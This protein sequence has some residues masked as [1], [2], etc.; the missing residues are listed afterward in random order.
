MTEQ[1]TT[2]GHDSAGRF[3]AGNPGGPGN[4]HASQVARL[5]STMLEAVT[6]DDMR[7]VVAKLVELAKGGDVK[8]IQLLMDRTIGKPDSGPMVAVQ[9]NVQR[10]DAERR[11]AMLRIIHRIR[12]ERAAAKEAS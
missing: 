9:H 12:A 11:E 3:V 5:R 2:N 6:D 4:P 7:D 10:T 8:A 1:P